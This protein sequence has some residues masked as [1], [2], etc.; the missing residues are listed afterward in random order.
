[1]LLEG[2]RQMYFEIWKVVLT[3]TSLLLNLCKPFLCKQ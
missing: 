2:T 3:Q 1:M